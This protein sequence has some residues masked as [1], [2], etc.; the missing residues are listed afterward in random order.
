MGRHNLRHVF[1][2]ITGDLPA[3]SKA[4]GRASAPDR[5]AILNQGEQTDRKAALG[6]GVDR[7]GQ[8]RRQSQHSPGREPMR[9]PTRSITRTRC[10]CRLFPSATIAPRASLSVFPAFAPCLR[11]L[12]EIAA[13]CGR[14]SEGGFS[15]WMSAYEP[16]MRSA[17]GQS[18]RSRTE[19]VRRDRTSGSNVR[20]RKGFH[21]VAFRFR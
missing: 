17:R 4:A 21:Y 3:R 13:G 8:G 19:C 10:G 1:D 15:F 20:C 12:L 18:R 9:L 11:S 6:S 5:R 16:A 2:G 7:A 14:R